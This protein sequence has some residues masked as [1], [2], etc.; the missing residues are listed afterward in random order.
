MP[1]F[2][3]FTLLTTFTYI[4]LRSVKKVKQGAS[5]GVLNL[6]VGQSVQSVEDFNRMFY[7]ALLMIC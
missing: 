4:I 1:D 6:L 5:T 3:T 2:L 7:N